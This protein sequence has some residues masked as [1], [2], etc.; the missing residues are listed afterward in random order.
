MRANLPFPIK[1]YVK[2]SPSYVIYPLEY[3]MDFN[4]KPY[5]LVLLTSSVGCEDGEFDNNPTG[6]D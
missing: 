1:I 4:N 6:G 3:W 5:E 2:K